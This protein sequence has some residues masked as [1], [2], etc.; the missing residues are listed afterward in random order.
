[1]ATVESQRAEQFLIEY[2]RCEAQLFAYLMTLLGNRTDAEEVFQETALALW[3]S[4]NDFAPGTN[5]LSWAKRIAFH[6]VL[7]F[8]K[9]RQRQGVP[10]SEEFL[11]SVEQLLS[12]DSGKM[13]ARLQALSNCVQKLSE[14]DRQLIALRY[15]SNKKIKDLANDLNRPANTLYKAFER[16]RHALYECVDRALAREEHI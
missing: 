2:S 7:T 15:E 13:D 3:R 8:R 16:I 9:L 12:S 6:R 4:F 10:G 1:M 5:F 14:T 11:N